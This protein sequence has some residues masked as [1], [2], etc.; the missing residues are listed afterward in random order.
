MSQRP[1][2]RRLALA[3]SIGVVIGAAAMFVVVVYQG[4]QRSGPPVDVAASST[5]NVWDEHART[6]CQEA[7]RDANDR[8]VAAGKKSVVR[9]LRDVAQQQEELNYPDMIKDWC[10]RNARGN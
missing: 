9:E 6:A 1:R 4:S 8:A 10:A 7:A 5:A 2:I 3:V